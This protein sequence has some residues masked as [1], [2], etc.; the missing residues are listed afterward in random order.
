MMIVKFRSGT[1]LKEMLHKVKKM[2]KFTK[3]LRKCLEDKAEEDEDD[4]DYRYEEDDD[5]IMEHRR[6][7]RNRR[8]M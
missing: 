3:E 8:R 5:D 6:A 1:E 4:E 2:E 7:M